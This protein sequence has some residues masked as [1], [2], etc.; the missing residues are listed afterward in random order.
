[1]NNLRKLR[2]EKGF[3]Q[4][5]V[6]DAINVAQPTYSRY[7]LGTRKLEGD[8]LISLSQFFN[9]SIDYILGNIDEP[10]TL[11]ELQFLKDLKEKSD[12]ELISKHNFVDDDG[13]TMTKDD[14][15]KMLEILRAYED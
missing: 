13:K 5:E 14:I 15:K 10:V 9:V 3:K 11:D 7:E 8:I 2:K 12:D 4:S 1:M 6:A